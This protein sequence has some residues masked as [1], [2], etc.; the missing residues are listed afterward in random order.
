MPLERGPRGL[1]AAIQA[2]LVIGRRGACVFRVMCMSG[3]AVSV[4]FAA[5]LLPSWISGADPALKF[6]MCS[7]R[8]IQ[9]WIQSISSC[10]PDITGSALPDGRNRDATY[11]KCVVGA[12]GRR[13]PYDYSR[14]H[15]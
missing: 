14:G 1:A 8:M 11:R 7:G 3:P 12:S 4:S 15:P 5:G 10:M 9:G 6:T 13:T 2:L